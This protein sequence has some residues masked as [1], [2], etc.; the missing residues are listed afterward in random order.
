MYALSASAIK[1]RMEGDLYSVGKSILLSLILFRIGRLIFIHAVV[2]KLPKDNALV[3]CLSSG[4]TVITAST[5][6]HHFLVFIKK[7]KK[8]MKTT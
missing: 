8:R 1:E 5:L 2:F 4:L 6:V 7:K 3:Y